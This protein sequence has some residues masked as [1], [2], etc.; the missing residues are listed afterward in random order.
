MQVP[1]SL[2]FLPGCT[3]AVVWPTDL[4][5][6]DKNFLANLATKLLPHSVHMWKLFPLPHKKLSENG[7]DTLYMDSAGT[8]EIE[9]GRATDDYAGRCACKRDRHVICQIGNREREKNKEFHENPRVIRQKGSR[10]K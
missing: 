10:E 4:E 6:F 8:R 5:N 9:T 2:F 1:L 7:R 3:A